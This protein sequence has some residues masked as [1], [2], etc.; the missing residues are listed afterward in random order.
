[1]QA[2]SPVSLQLI[3]SPS[4]LSQGFCNIQEEEEEEEE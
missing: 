2:P 1:M 3:K 4:L